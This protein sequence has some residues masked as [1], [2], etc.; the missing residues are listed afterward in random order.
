[1]KKIITLTLSPAFD[2]HCRCDGLALYE[3][4]LAHVTSLDAGGK[5]INIARALTANDTPCF[6]L[7][8]LGEDN[9]DA[10]EKQ[11]FREKIAYRAIKRPGRIRENVTI[12][13]QG[14]AETQEGQSSVCV[15]SQL[16]AMCRTDEPPG[17]ERAVGYMSRPTSAADGSL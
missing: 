6:A 5:G 14:K 1:M 9:C 8:V 12:H 2:L 3:E 11:L 17:V 15:E 7:T 13:T 4:N 10:F 16:R